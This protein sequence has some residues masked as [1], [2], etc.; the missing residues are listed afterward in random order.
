M[1]NW[2]IPKPHSDNKNQTN[3]QNN[4]QLHGK[5]SREPDSRIETESCV[6]MRAAHVGVMSAAAF[7][8][9][10]TVTTVGRSVGTF[11]GNND[12]CSKCGFSRNE[13]QGVVSWQAGTSCVLSSQADLI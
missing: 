4:G 13:S 9:L 1:F 7:G 5:Q 8:D 6:N 11:R 10:P 2:Q 12:F 3:G